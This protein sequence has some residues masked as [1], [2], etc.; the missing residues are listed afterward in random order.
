MHS[1]VDTRFTV[2]GFS[3][4][5]VMVLWLCRLWGVSRVKC[6]GRY[7]LFSLHRCQSPSCSSSIY[8]LAILLSVLLAVILTIILATGVLTAIG[9]RVLLAILLV[10]FYTPCHSPRSLP[11][12][13]HSRMQWFQTY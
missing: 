6:I 13:P 9:R 5:F 10:V 4:F 2:D 7:P 1:F 12:H 3:R 8:I 11:S